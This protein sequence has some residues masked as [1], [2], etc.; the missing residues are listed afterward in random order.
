MSTSPQRIPWQIGRRQI[1]LAGQPLIMGIVNLTPD[2]FSDGGQWC[3]ISAAVDH[4][5]QLEAD[6]AHF[7]D[8]GGESTRPGATPV[9]VDEELRRVIPV[10]TALAGRVQIPLSIDTTKSQVAREALAAGAAIINDISGLRYDDAM[11]DVCCEFQAGVICM[12]MQG[13][14]QTMQQAPH[15]TDVVSEICDFFR[16][17]QQEL[18]QRGIH[19]NQLVWDPGVGF[20]KTAEHNITILSSI[21]RFRQLGRP[22]LIGHS[23]KRFLQRVIGRPVDERQYGTLG[24]SLGVASQ[25]ADIIRVHDVAAHRDALVAYQAVTQNQATRV[26]ACGE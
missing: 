19:A 22:I 2:S 5:V 14:P 3:D 24:V 9:T 25:G 7:L 1:T 13:T 18:T 11:A 17:R 8:L 12:H 21:A 26:E 23:R 20:G 10:L 15:Y 16:S 6:G 4:A